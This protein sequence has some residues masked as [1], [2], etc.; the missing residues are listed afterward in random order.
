MSC[1]GVNNY[2]D[3]NDTPWKRSTSLVVPVSCCKLHGQVIDFKPEDPTCVSSPTESNSF[4]MKVFPFSSP[5]E[6]IVKSSFHIVRDAIL[7]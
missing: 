3:F 2:T 4:R 6:I 7:A 1:C 5:S